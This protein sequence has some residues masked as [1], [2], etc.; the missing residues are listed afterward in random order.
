MTDL[1]F[2]ENMYVFVLFVSP[3]RQTNLSARLSSFFFSVLAGIK[4]LTW[5]SFVEFFYLAG[6]HNR[7][8]NV[9]FCTSTT[10]RASSGAFLAEKKIV[11]HFLR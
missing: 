2:S 7:F 5:E 4:E 11:K 3:L 9:D 10:P 1:G 6:K 8:E